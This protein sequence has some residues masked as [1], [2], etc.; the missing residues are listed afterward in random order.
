MYY[1]AASVCLMSSCVDSD[2]SYFNPDE[3]KEY[4]ENEYFIKDIDP[5]M[6][7]K[8][9]RS[10]P[11]AVSINED[12][13]V[14]Y[15]ISIFSSN[16]LLEGDNA[17]LLAEGSANNGMSFNTTADIPNALS[18]VYV[19]RTDEKNRNLVKIVGVEDGQIKA[20]FGA[21]TATS[22]TTRSGAE[23]QTMPFDKSESDVL[24]MISSATEMTSGITL[25][26]GGTYKIS[27]GNTLQGMVANQGFD[28]RASIIVEG[29]WDLSGE[30]TKINKGVDLYIVNG[31]Q[32]ILPSEEKQLEIIG[33]S[34]FAVYPG[35]S[36]V[37]QNAT[38]SVTNASGGRI[39]FNA[40]IID[41]KVLS[42]ASWEATTGVYNTGTLK[43]GNLNFA[44]SATLINHG[45]VEAK[46]MHDNTKIENA[47]YMKVETLGASSI[48]L[49]SNSAINA[50]NWKSVWG[51][52]IQMAANSMITI[53]NE[54]N[55]SG[56]TIIGPSNEY[57]L[58]K[59]QALKD[60]NGFNNSGNIYYEVDFTD[61]NIT[62]NGWLVE[63]F[64]S[65][66]KN[67]DGAIAKFGESPITIPAGEC[68]GEGNTPSEQGEEI[69]TNNNTIT[70]TFEDNFPLV[71]DYDMNDIVLDVKTQYN[72]DA[73][74][75]ITSADVNI[76]LVAVGA[77]KQIGAAMRL[78][79]LTRSDITSVTF[80]DEKGIR[81]TLGNSIFG[82]DTYEE[83]GDQVII[84]LFG[85]GHRVYGEDKVDKMLNT[86]YSETE[87]LYSMTI[88]IIPSVQSANPF[89]KKDNMDIFIAYPARSTTNKR[90]EVHL[91]EFWGNGLT[92]R[93]LNQEANMAAAGNR[94][95]AIAVP[96]FKYPK[97]GVLISEA[98]PE[99]AEWAKDHNT[100]L[101]WYKNTVKSS[102]I[103][104]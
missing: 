99:F 45:Q 13:G 37:G 94:T 61:N 19:M 78:I 39:N 14:N 30:S 77:T 4:Y 17:L 50:T 46:T 97:E 18:A 49:S 3:T 33:T 69:P 44:N 58:V 76:T 43:A 9:T 52:Q 85:D 103:N 34:C 28:T 93:A 91:Y 23:I 16:P 25:Q 55:L 81:N 7:W 79:G 84:P 32:L 67:T 86:G 40:G 36:I 60:I 20:S 100:N 24:A 71:G 80:T 42:V 73:E 88:H 63:N 56:A 48:K 72:R 41:V 59:I 102:I 1:F 74:N 8:T 29:T 11:V 2:K 87:E 75:K 68:T 31:G 104:R 82:A 70:Y 54:A 6:D 65:K 89:I 66:I 83:D 101:E 53:S 95:W 35:S 64:L 12:L 62:N 47:C 26:A 98:Y 96:N 10:V 51:S 21:K 38:L 15:K 22:R 5:S 57:A 90:S 92:S 27:K